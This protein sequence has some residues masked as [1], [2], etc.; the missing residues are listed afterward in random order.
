VVSHAPATGIVL[1]NPQI[2]GR[3]RDPADGSPFDRL[4]GD[5]VVFAGGNSYPIHRGTPV[6]IDERMS[7][8]SVRDIVEHVPTTQRLDY[9]SRDHMKN[10][11][12]QVIFPTLSKDV[13]LD[14]RYSELAKVVAGE[15]VLVIG[16]G[17]SADFYR[18]C[19]PKSEVVTSDVHCQF[20]VDVVLDGHSIPF[21]DETFAL[22]LAPQVLEHTSRPWIV[23]SELQR[24]TKREGHL[25]VEVPFA[26]P[27][28]G[29]PYDFYRFTPSALR[30]LFPQCRMTKLE[31]PESTWSAAAV[32]LSTALID[33]FAN[34]HLRMMA[35]AAGRLALWWLK[36]LDRWISNRAASMPKGYAV[37][38]VVDGRTRNE[39]ELLAEVRQL[40]ARIEAL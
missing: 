25:Q 17:D 1:R 30:F 35:L 34:R 4:E 3:L 24:V 22:V 9:R 23:A 28:H 18:R 39:K 40:L 37:T 19:F 2:L 12:R 36:Y 21:R 5:R 31:V 13:S 16:T 15:T 11:I 8:F 33:S 14:A 6:L 38:Y 26:F 20:G 29:A 7:I 27:C 32:A 10:F